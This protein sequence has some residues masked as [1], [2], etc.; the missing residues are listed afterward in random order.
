MTDYDKTINKCPKCGCI[1]VYIGAN[2]IECGYNANCENF[3]QN[4]A[5]E[6]LKLV[7]AQQEKIKKDKKVEGSEYQ[8]DLDWDDEE[9]ITKPITPIYFSYTTD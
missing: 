4:Q 8:I 6:I 5:I 2:K 3:T 9:I 7:K 1:N